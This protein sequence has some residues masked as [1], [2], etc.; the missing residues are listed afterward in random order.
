[1][2]IYKSDMPQ[3]QA[4]EALFVTSGK[5]DLLALEDIGAQVRKIYRSLL[6]ADWKAKGFN[7][8]ECGYGW[9]CRECPDQPVCDDIR[10]VIKV[11]KRRNGGSDTPSGEHSH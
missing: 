9:D 7:V 5:E 4:L 8:Y 10:D 3:V 1:M 2:G 6:T 11:R